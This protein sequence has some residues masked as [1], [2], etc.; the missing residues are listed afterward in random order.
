MEALLRMVQL[1]QQSYAGVKRKLRDLGY[2]YMLLYPAKLEV[3]HAGRAHFFQSPQ[4]VWDWLERSNGT[5]PPRS[6]RRA[7]G[8]KPQG[9]E[10]V[11]TA[12]HRSTRRHR[13]GRGSRVIVC[14]SGTLTLERKRQE[15][16]EAKLL[17]QTVTSEASL[18][19]GSPGA[20]SGLSPERE[21]EIT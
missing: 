7:S 9:L 6:P 18:R 13:T 14:L 17:V 15:R 21:A 8:G 4:A 2:T 20:A 19:S 3:L 11:R 5:G 10:E 1:Q 12:V 16:E